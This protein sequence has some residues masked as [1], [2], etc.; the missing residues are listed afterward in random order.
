MTRRTWMAYAVVLGLVAGGCG[1]EAGGGVADTQAITDQPAGTSNG[2]PVVGGNSADG[3]DIPLA[4]G[5]DGV[6]SFDSGPLTTVQFIVPL[7]R[8]EATIA[9]YD[10]WTAGQPIE[11]IRSESEA[12]GVSWQTPTVPGTDKSV[13]SVLSPIAG[14]D[15]VTVTLSVGPVE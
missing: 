15:F 2:E 13:I 14:D 7:D 1:G 8:L 12:G 11:Y 10:D 5:A 4:P 6:A 3:V 9:F